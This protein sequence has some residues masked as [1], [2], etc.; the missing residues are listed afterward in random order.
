MKL[1]EQAEATSKLLDIFSDSFLLEELGP[2]LTCVECD[3]LCEWLRAYEDCEGA[4]ILMDS[5]AMSDDEG[6]KHFKHG[7][8]LRGGEKT[9]K[10]I[11]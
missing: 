8:Q 3:A 9:K 1:V 5:H 4:G 10:G 2:K 6:D 7:E 11:Q